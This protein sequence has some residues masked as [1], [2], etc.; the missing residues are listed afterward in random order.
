MHGFNLIKILV[1]VLANYALSRRVKGSRYATAFSWLFVGAALVASEKT[2]GFQGWLPQAL[3]RLLPFFPCLSLFLRRITHRCIERLRVLP[4]EKHSGLLPRWHINFN[5]TA[6]RLLSF[7]LDAH[8]AQAGYPSHGSS[9][10]TTRDS[11]QA[12]EEEEVPLQ[13]D[14]LNVR[15]GRRLRASKNACADSE[16]L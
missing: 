4:Q 7:S 11:V 9:S 2:S 13:S 15:P 3:V 12:R 5:I 8:W 14:L 6:L 16:T 1:L 10:S